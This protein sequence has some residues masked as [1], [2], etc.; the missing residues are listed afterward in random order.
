MDPPARGRCVSQ[1]PEYPEL[2]VLQLLQEHHRCVIKHVPDGATRT[3][4]RVIK[5]RSS[6]EQKRSKP[7]ANFSIFDS[8]SHSYGR[9]RVA[10][11]LPIMILAF[12]RKK[13]VSA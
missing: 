3:P 1:L 13:V 6:L 12:F 5:K 2:W 8:A 11:Q 4:V 7:R 10:V 9:N